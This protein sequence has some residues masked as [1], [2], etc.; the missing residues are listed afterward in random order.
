MNL[1]IDN[2]LH[3]V[4]ELLRNRIALEIGDPFAAQ[5]ARLSCLLLRIGA[6][7]VDDA[8]DLR[9]TENAALRALLGDIALLAEDPLASSLAAATRSNDPGLRLSVLD[10]ESHRL[11]SLLVEAHAF[12]ETAQGETARQLDRR[13]WQLLETIEANRAPRE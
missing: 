3:G 11:R 9:V 4:E 1:S 12:V 13:I 7:W 2:A 8:A 6:N 5:M 10:E